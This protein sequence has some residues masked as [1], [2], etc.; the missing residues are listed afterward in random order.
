MSRAARL[1]AMAGA[2]PCADAD[3]LAVDRTDWPPGPWDDELDRYDFKT[4]AGLPAIIYR[5][6]MGALCG[7]VGVAPGHP[8]HGKECSE[9]PFRGLRVH[10]GVSY[11]AAC[12]ETICHV[13]APGEPDNV[14]WVGFDCCRGRDL[15]PVVAQM[16][17]RLSGKREL[18]R[19]RDVAFV[20]AWCEALAEQ[21]VAMGG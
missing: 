6:G 11:A 18:Y 12:N 7:Y 10:G 17:S 1:A 9:E 16:Q 14:W 19:Y 15:I 8:C 3:S 4:A 2:A 13:P 21:L 20:R 5:N